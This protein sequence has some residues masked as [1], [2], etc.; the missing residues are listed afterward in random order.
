ML[1][2]LFVEAPGSEDKDFLKTVRGIQ[3]ESELFFSHRDKSCDVVEIRLANEEDHDDL[4]A[5]FNSQSEVLT[6]QF[7]EFFIADLIATQNKT[8]NNTK[9]NKHSGKALVA[10]V[11]EK[12][13]G[14]MSL[15]TEI[16]YKLLAQNFDLEMYDNLFKSDLFNCISERISDINEEKK[17][18]Q[19]LE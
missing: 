8:R 16:D 19:T 17:W 1:S 13:V 3:P 14:L 18:Q 4:A 2:D 9:N 6:N 12:A 7:G 10:Q 15:S 11:K 5:I